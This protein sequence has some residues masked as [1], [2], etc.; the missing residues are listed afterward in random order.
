MCGKS[1]RFST[2][3]NDCFLFPILQR[4]LFSQQL[5]INLPVAVLEHVENDLLHALVSFCARNSFTV[6]TAISAAFSFGK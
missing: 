3:K 1:S 5:L 6:A 2:S 4:L